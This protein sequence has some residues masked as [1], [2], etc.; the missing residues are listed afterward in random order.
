MFSLPEE[1]FVSL[2]IYNSIGELVSELVNQFKSPGKYKV[3]FDASELSSGV[4][5]YKL[6]T[7]G[8]RKINKMILLK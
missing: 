8:Y 5:F 7:K 6:E 4:Y 3:S 2:K 1:T